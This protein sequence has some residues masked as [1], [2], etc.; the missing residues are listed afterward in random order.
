M[1][2]SEP[3]PTV[4]AK[5]DWLTLTGKSPTL[6]RCYADYVQLANDMLTDLSLDGLGL[7]PVNPNP[8]YLHAFAIGQGR[9]VIHLAEDVGR[10][11]VMLVLAGQ[12]LAQCDDQQ[13]LLAALAAGWKVTRLDMAYDFLNCGESIAATYAAY[14]SVEHQ[15]KRRTTYIESEQGDTLYIGSRSSAKMLRLYNKGAEQRLELDWIRLE[16]EYKAEAASSAAAALA[17]AQP[18]ERQYALAADALA[19]L[20]TPASIYTVLLEFGGAAIVRS[21]PLTK[22]STELWLHQSVLPALRKFRRQQPER[23]DLWLD[24]LLNVITEPLG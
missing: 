14:Q 24:A 18:F 15:P 21:T 8:F 11:G 2:N 5:I 19:M 10:Q 1:S 13:M 16:V 17:S 9:G 12:A 6:P 7:Q 23:F 3:R 22:G 4:S 20:D